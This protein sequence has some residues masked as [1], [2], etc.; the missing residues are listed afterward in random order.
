MLLYSHVRLDKVRRDNVRRD[1][2]A[3]L[4]LK[5][6]SGPSLPRSRNKGAEQTTCLR[7]TEQ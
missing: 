3:S 6:S 4:I 1:N 7:G 5:E 2:H